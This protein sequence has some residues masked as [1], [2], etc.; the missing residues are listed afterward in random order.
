MR[1]PGHA[2]QQDG[3]GDSAGKT[4]EDRRWHDQ[5]ADEID[6]KTGAAFGPATAHQET[7]KP[8]GDDAARSGQ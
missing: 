7:G 8:S 3:A 6:G 5:R 4:T 1:E 2:E